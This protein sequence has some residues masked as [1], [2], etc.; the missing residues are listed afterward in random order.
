MLVQGK[1]VISKFGVLKEWLDLEDFSLSSLTFWFGFYKFPML[2]SVC[3]GE[4][5]WNQGSGIENNLCIMY[6][7]SCILQSRRC[8]DAAAIVIFKFHS[9]YITIIGLLVIF[10][11]F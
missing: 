10:P 5:F 9:E 1:L 8:L 4:G 7:I 3:F 11:V 6:L 2:K